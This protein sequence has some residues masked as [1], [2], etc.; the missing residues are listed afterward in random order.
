MDISDN[1]KTI[2]LFEMTCLSKLQIQ[3]KWNIQS[4]PSKRKQWPFE[5][6][7]D[8]FKKTVKFYGQYF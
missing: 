3:H 8:F 4:D 7:N 1:R 2:F 5:T 6:L